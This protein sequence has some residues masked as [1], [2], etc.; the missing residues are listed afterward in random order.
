MALYIANI[1]IGWLEKD[2][3]GNTLKE[4]ISSVESIQDF[5]CLLRM[6][7]ET[8]GKSGQKELDKLE[9]FLKKYHSGDL[10]IKDIEEL[11]VNLSIGQ[12]KCNR[13]EIIE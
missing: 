11:N 10:V 8:E 6:G 13:I 9:A 4:L 2:F 7:R 3:E 5:D 12:I 1:K